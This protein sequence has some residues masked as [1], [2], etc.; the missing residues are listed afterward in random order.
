MDTG[1]PS[2]QLRD[3]LPLLLMAAIAALPPL[4]VDMYLP[5]IPQIADDFGSSIST[6]Q[7]SLSVFLLGFGLGMLVY[8]PLSDRHGRRPLA[9]FGL[10]AFALSSALLMLSPSGVW[11]LALRLLKGFLGSAATI[12]IPAMIRDCYGKDTAKGMSSVFMIML[13]APLVAPLLGSLTLTLL[14]WEGIFGFLA[15]Y[16]ATLLVLAWHLLP[17]TL[18]A[19][20]DAQPR[21]GLLGSYGIILGKPQIYCDLVCYMLSA[22]AFFTYLTS[23][24]FLYITW[25]GASETLF[26]VLFAFSAGALIVANWINVRLVARHGPRRLMR[27]GLGVGL[28]CAVLLQL[29]F[30]LELGLLWTVATFV[31]I[32]G[33][34]GLSSVNADALVLIQFPRQASSASAVTGTLRFGFGA[35]AGPLLAWSHDGT[36]APIGWLVIAALAGACLAQGAQQLLFG[37]SEIQ[38]D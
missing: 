2:A 24:S 37:S 25:F 29:G 32:V 18:P 16:A 6:I 5:A 27:A 1:A 17:E 22:L 33:C 7:N 9:L 21:P 28:A 14:P 19:H 26:G 30:W 35:V 8:G 3:K 13:V 31:G 36:P 10:A 38:P 23:V 11:F 4:A 20:N 12:V 34:L 15:L